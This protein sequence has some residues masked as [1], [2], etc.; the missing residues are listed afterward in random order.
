MVAMQ[1]QI[2]GIKKSFISSL[3]QA[4]TDDQLEHLRIA[5]LGR[6]G[7]ITLL[8]K[9]IKNLSV[10]E[11]R[12]WGPKLNQFKQEAESAFQ[13]KKEA[14]FIEQLQSAQQKEQF[15]DV[16]AYEPNQPRGS[17]HVYT[18]TVQRLEDIFI[19]MGYNVIE[20]PEI[21]TD[22]Y[23]FEALNIPADHPA[24]DHHDT[25]WINDNQLLRTHTSPVQAR[26][27]ETHGTPIA[28]F[29]PGRTFRHEAT[30]ASHDF[31]FMQGEVLYIDKHVS[32]SNL[33]AT[34]KTF[35][36]AFFEKEDLTVRARPGYF[37]FVE[38]GIEIDASCPFCTEGCSICKKTGWIELL[39]SGLVHPNVLRCSGIDPET[40]SGF[41]LGF[42][43][44]R[45]AMIKYGI[46]DI[47][48]FHSSNLHFLDQ[49]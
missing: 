45:L 18:R 3:E 16:T 20:G 23:N 6:Q 30:D 5:F 35:L 40:Y 49:F 2:D 39:G 11:K 29:A 17:L 27:L 48:L 14:L 22:Y 47:R 10:D 1:A 9:E 41:A 28:V 44:E 7:S 24:R 8:M 13:E 21:E 25:F 37:P 32:I 46:N 34:A 19:S 4:Q 42:G 26:A 43:I 15:F 36:Q 31:M 33:L 12:V 38:P